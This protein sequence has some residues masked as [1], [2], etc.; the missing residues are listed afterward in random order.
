VTWLFWPLFLA[1]LIFV[2]LGTGLIAYAVA[3][4][5]GGYV[6]A[7]YVF[8]AGAGAYVG[9]LVCFLA[10]AVDG[11]AGRTAYVVTFFVSTLVWIVAY[12][13]AAS[14]AQAK[15]RMPQ[16]PPLHTSLS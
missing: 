14:R 8:R 3:L 11:D 15:G 13:V 2:L 7:G 4:K 10:W 12:L 6:A 1:P 16:H 9:G 5:R